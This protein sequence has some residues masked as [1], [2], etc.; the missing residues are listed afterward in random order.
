[1]TGDGFKPMRQFG[2]MDIHLSCLKKNWWVGFD[3]WL[4]Q[5]FSLVSKNT[6]GGYK[7]NN[8]VL[9]YNS[10]VFDYGTYNQQYRMGLSPNGWHHIF[11]GYWGY[12]WIETSHFFDQVLGLGLPRLILDVGLWIVLILYAFPLMSICSMFSLLFKPCL[13]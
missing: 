4:E 8:I 10:V 2:G 7:K 1:M 9:V 13:M 6:W 11:L 5:E 3:R 12:W